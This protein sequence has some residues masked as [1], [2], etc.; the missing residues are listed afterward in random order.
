MNRAS[1]YLLTSGAKE[2]VADRGGEGHS[3]F[4]RAFLKGPED[5]PEE[6]F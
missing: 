5:Y 3:V 1:R 2:Q 6:A 4:A